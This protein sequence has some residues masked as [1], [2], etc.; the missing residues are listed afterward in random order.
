MIMFCR[1]E[2]VMSKTLR[3]VLALSF[4]FLFCAN[5][6]CAAQFE[7][8]GSV[9]TL[10]Y[11]PSSTVVGDFNRDGKLD[12][13]VVERDGFGGYVMILMGN[14]DGTFRTGTSYAV[15]HR[16]SSAASVSFRKNG[17]LDL[18]VGDAIDDF[19][20]V[21]LGNGDGTFQDPIP[22]ALTGRTTAV[23][24]GDFTGSGKTD[25]LALEGS[26][27]YCVEVV[28]GN[29]DG[30]F[31]ARITTPL[32][33]NMSGYAMAVGD[34]SGYGKLDVAFVGESIPDFQLAILLGNGDGSFG[35]DG[36][37]FVSADPIS[38]ATG[39]FNND[40]IPDLA[41]A[42][43]MGGGLSVLL[44][45]GN[46]LFEQAVD[47]STYYPSWVAAADLN[48]DGYQDLVAANFDTPGSS[49]GSLTVFPGNDDGTFQPGVSYPAGESV[50]N[51]AI[52]DFNGDHKPDLLAV[53]QTGAL[54]TLLNTGTVSFSPTTGANFPLQLVGT[55]SAPLTT[56]LTNNGTSALVI[57]SVSFSGDPFK[58]QTT[59][60]GTI[61]PGG[62][63]TIRATFTAA[64]KDVTTGKV[65][66][67][68]SASSK[69]QVVELVGT[70]TVAKFSPTE[71]TFKPQKNGSK[72]PAQSI[73]LTNTGAV[74]LNLASI[75]IIGGPDTNADFFESNNCPA[76]LRADAS[77]TIHV[78]F[79][80]RE[81]G[82]I[83]ASVVFEDD[84]GGLLQYVPLSG[85]GD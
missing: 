51:G 23:G 43:L 28:P 31:G 7:T 18:V 75:S 66:I 61:A 2:V 10:P 48:G 59:C 79:A 39:H 33:Y 54:N 34:F 63:C 38:I 35:A 17:T 84:G 3:I 67:H 58:T 85:T 40:M 81:T 8:R 9:I 80:P 74:P 47:Y 60:H 56:T 29:G 50:V 62:H 16:P 20:Y 27:C 32:P 5:T 83:N 76:S 11:S 41:V 57:S 52:G 42:N 45:Q 24:V 14:G 46:G 19:A 65:T 21:L 73:R 68:D 25:I 44:G 37:Y 82:P 1:C 55:T 6:N 36:F 12:A 64:V 30:T 4:A 69:P 22:V 13:A 26:G 77:C 49:A 15:T 70:G 72:S 71:I 78:I 53:D